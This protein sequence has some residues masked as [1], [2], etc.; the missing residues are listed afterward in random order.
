MK[1]V[2]WQIARWNELY[3]NSESR[4]L[5]RL[6]W[7]PISNSHDGENFTLLMEQEDAFLIFAAWI[8]ILQVASKTKHRGV[9]VKDDGTPHDA[10]SLALKTR[11]RTEWF[12]RALPFLINDLEWIVPFSGRISRDAGRKSR[13][14]GPEGKGRGNVKTL[15]SRE[16]AQVVGMGMLS[17]RDRNVT[18]VPS[19]F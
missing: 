17:L 4:K 19:K 8:L 11:S 5:K 12:Q 3:E 7:V 6:K 15:N 13:H 2:I 14:T 9:L 16:L 18:P 10:R 1:P